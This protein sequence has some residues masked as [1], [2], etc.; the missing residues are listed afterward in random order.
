[1]RFA[2]AGASWVDIGA[3]AG[4]P[5][6]VIALLTTGPVTL[7]EPRKLR[8][9]FLARVCEEVRIANRVTVVTAMT[10]M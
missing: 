5:G 7:I 9:D 1:M 10:S 8:A 6:L 2:P 3:G 4:L